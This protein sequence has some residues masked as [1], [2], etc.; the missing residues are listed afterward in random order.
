M[1]TEK[2]GPPLISRVSSPA[3]SPHQP[4]SCQVSVTFVLPHGLLTMRVDVC[5]WGAL[6]PS[7][8][9]EGALAGQAPGCYCRCT[10]FQG[11]SCSWAIA[12]A[13]PLQ[14]GAGNNCKHNAE[15]PREEASHEENDDHTKKTQRAPHEAFLVRHETKSA[16]PVQSRVS[17]EDKTEK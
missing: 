13:H 7:S 15:Y 8:P 17:E 4:R 5:C 10:G 12:T 9:P 6:D 3:V 11:I 1:I 16:L 14:P 2:I